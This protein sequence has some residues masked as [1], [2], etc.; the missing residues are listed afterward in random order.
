[1]DEISADA[2]TSDLRTQD[3]SLSFWQCGKE[4]AVRLEEVALAIAAGRDSVDRLDIVWLVDDELKD[5]GQTLKST[6]GRTP[7]VELSKLHVDVCRLDYI[8]LGNIA[9]RVVRA[10][11]ENRYKRISKPRVKKLLTDAAGQGRID[12]DALEDKV[13]SEVLESLETRK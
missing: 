10:L 2:I 5:D 13:K 1:M 4:E 9:R 7:V 11:E 3:N 8:R 6:E 12:I